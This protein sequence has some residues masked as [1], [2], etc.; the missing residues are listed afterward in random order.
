[1]VHVCRSWFAVSICFPG[2]QSL[3]AHPAGIGFLSSAIVLVRQTRDPRF[4]FAQVSR[5]SFVLLS[6]V[7]ARVFHPTTT[8]GQS[9]LVPSPFDPP[10]QD[11]ATSSFPSAAWLHFSCRC[12]PRSLFSLRR[13]SSP[14]SDSRRKQQ[15][16][17][18]S[19]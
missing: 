8:P 10:Q 6:Q 14:V 2:F 4:I 1:V 18:P 7:A 3:A 5:S 11:R 19:S 9:V 16:G 15:L 12:A 13:G 17:V